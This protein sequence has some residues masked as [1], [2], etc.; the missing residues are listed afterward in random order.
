[1]SDIHSHYNSVSGEGKLNLPIIMAVT[2][3]MLE[4]NRDTVF[5][6]LGS[7]EHLNHFKGVYFFLQLFCSHHHAIPSSTFALS[8]LAGVPASTS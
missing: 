6:L 3:H 2:E 4:L 7:R 1:M 5:N 8:L